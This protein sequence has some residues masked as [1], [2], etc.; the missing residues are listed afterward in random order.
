MTGLIASLLNTFHQHVKE[1]MEFSLK[2]DTRKADLWDHKRNDPV[3][4]LWNRST[5]S[6]F[7]ASQM[8]V[9]VEVKC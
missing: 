3:H 4:S 6:P 7:L 1:F 5:V 2:D 9:E 8:D